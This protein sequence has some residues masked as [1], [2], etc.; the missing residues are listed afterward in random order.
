MSLVPL[1]VREKKQDSQAA[2]PAPQ[3]QSAHVFIVQRGTA[4]LAVGY[5]EPITEIVG[6]FSSLADANQAV[7]LSQRHFMEEFGI[8]NPESEGDFAG[9]T[10][11][12][13]GEVAPGTEPSP[14]GTPVGY[15][16]EFD[17]GA[18]FLYSCRVRCFSLIPAST[19]LVISK[20]R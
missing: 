19:P 17:D 11:E 12:E 2:A 20:N 4:L 15:F 6:V 18:G 3:K 10:S 5:E 1:P 13:L 9:F 7:L 14:A 16:W 8:A